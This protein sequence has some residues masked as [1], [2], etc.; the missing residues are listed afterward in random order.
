[1]TATGMRLLHLYYISNPNIHYRNP[2][3]ALPMLSL[4][5]RLARPSLA[6]RCLIDQNQPVPCI[7]I[8]QARRRIYRQGGAADHQHIRLRQG[9]RRLPRSVP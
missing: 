6:R 5:T 9:A 2:S 4:M 8:D 7:V 3:K 1:M